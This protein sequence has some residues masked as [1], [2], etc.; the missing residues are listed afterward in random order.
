MIPVPTHSG[1][2]SLSLLSGAPPRIFVVLRTFSGN[3]RI[4]TETMEPS[5]RTFLYVQPSLQLVLVLDDDS[6]ADHA[7][8]EELIASM[9]W[10]HAHSRGVFHVVYSPAVPEPVLRFR[11]F[12][13]LGGKYASAGYTRQL[14]DTFFLDTMLPASTKPTVNDVI[15]IMDDDSPL[16]AVFAPSAILFGP[17][18]NVAIIPAKIQS[19]YFGD[20]ILLNA[21]HLSVLGV[22]ETD[23]FPQ[24]LRVGV[25]KGFREW[26]TWQ[27]NGTSFVDAWLAVDSAAKKSGKKDAGWL[28]PANVLWSW[29]AWH[30]VES[31]FHR[32]ALVGDNVSAVPVLAVNKGKLN[33]HPGCCRA[34][35][36]SL[37]NCSLHSTLDFDHITTLSGFAANH[38][39]PS[40]LREEAANVAYAQIASW[41]QAQP[42]EETRQR[43]LLCQQL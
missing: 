43:V 15:A 5:L 4:W 30:P 24:L 42:T 20:S 6:Y 37:T 3:R 11:P 2:A 31:A 9:E 22:M 7:W 28:S 16:R 26:A 29:A 40:V 13:S 35:N 18:H 17:N 1:G 21:S 8:G 38:Q 32:S 19:H 12:S 34:F 14:W 25:F 33:V 36:A 23:A 39:W 27:V 41:V 10:K